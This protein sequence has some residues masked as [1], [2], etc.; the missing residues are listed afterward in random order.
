MTVAYS[1]LSVLLA[2]PSALSSSGTFN[3]NPDSP[4][5]PSNWGTLNITGNQCSGQKNSPIAVET[6]PCDVKEDYTL[7]VSN[8]T[9]N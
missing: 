6:T 9:L 3:Y 4:L 7:S 5:G 8:V 1:A 2:L